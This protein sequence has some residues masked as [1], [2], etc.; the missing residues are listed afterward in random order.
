[1]HSCCAFIEQCNKYKRKV[2]KEQ[3]LIE[4]LKK[5]FSA[6]QRGKDEATADRNDLLELIEIVHSS[7]VNTAAVI[8]SFLKRN[9][10]L[11]HGWSLSRFD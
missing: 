5:D 9:G 8:E 6:L 1:M 7:P 10:M 11:A 4:V 2:V 3:E